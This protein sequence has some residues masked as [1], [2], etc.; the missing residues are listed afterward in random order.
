MKFS[1]EQIK[2]INH[3]DGPALVLAVPGSGKTTVLLARINNLIS[4]GVNPDSIL[5]MTFSKS[6]ALDMEMRY[7]NQYDDNGVKFSTI[8]SFSYGVLRHFSNTTEKFEIIDTSQKYNKYNLVRQM[9]FH[10]RKRK[11]TDEKLDTFFRVSG[12]IKNTLMDYDDYVKKYGKAF[13]GFEKLYLEYEKFKS[14]NNLIDFDDMLLKCLEILQK[15]PF[16]LKYLQ[17]KFD[18]IQIDEGQDTS[19][20]QLKII[21][22]IASKNNNLFIVADDDQS[23]YG[24]RGA[25]SS[26]LL[27]FSKVYKDAK[28]YYM[29]ENYRSTKNITSVANILIKNNVERYDKVISTSKDSGDLINFNRTRN[30]LSQT[31]HVIES[32]KKDIENG[33]TAAILYRNNIS[34]L[35]FIP[36]IDIDYYIKDG[37]NAFFS[38]QIVRDIVDTIN[39]SKDL[40]DVKLFEKIYY[41]F[42]LF[43]KKD[44]VEQLK[45]M[46][47]SMD[48]IDRLKE[49]EGMNSFFLDNVYELSFNLDKLS[50]MSFD[51]AIDYI[52]FNMD[53]YE[54]LKELARR[55]GISMIGYDRVIDTLINISEG[56]NSVS[57][58]E[59]RAKEIIDKQRNMNNAN[60]KLV[61]STVHG[62]KGLE[63]DNVYLIDLIDKEFPSINSKDEDGIIEEERRLFYVGITRA[64]KRLSLYYPDVLYRSDVEK[65]SFLDEIEKDEL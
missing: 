9:Y 1:N 6:Q 21:S 57:S 60:S 47:S 30:T 2:A 63:F 38:H 32:A 49:V 23:I 54:Y 7:R 24:F 10:H 42:N 31:N 61:L 13:I 64:K 51:K 48:I 26:A 50:R 52:V 46:D 14:N 65:S 62:S 40:Y 27:D 25:S 28:I 53:Y 34:A 33:E 20:V 4:R 19:Y 36:R 29:Q 16:A 3:V 12:Y 58:F 35:S 41:K 59:K 37:K 44:F 18:Y 43:L 5:A 8:H 15:N 56:V 17:D 11:M 22:L 39:F 55:N 45:F